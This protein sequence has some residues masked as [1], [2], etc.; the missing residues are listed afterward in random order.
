MKS[1]HLKHTVQH[2]KCKTGSSF[3]CF[4]EF[5]INYGFQASFLRGLGLLNLTWMFWTRV[6]LYKVVDLSTT[7]YTHA[8]MRITN[9]L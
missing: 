3:A 9:I 6:I 8:S 7:I 4:C 2:T 5:I 1:L